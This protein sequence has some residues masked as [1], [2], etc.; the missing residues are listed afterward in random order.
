MFEVLVSNLCASNCTCYDIR[1]VYIRSYD[2]TGESRIGQLRGQ[3]DEVSRWWS[4]MYMYM[5]ICHYEC[6]VD[7]LHVQGMEST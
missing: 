5:C 6:S 1:T 3:V 7:P 4:Y 2:S